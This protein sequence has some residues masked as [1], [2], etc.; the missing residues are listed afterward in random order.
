MGWRVQVLLSPLA[1]IDIG[2]TDA[3]GR[4]DVRA[5]GRDEPRAGRSASY[6][7]PL[8]L[9]GHLGV[10]QVFHG[11]RLGDPSVAKPDVWTIPK[12]CLLL[13]KACHEFV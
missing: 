6:G 1:P 12:G 2:T 13:A 3:A 11:W 10:R 8:R 4:T 9:Y 7:L 5:L